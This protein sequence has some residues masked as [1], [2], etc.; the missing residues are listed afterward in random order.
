MTRVSYQMG[1]YV[2][3]EFHNNALLLCYVAFPHLH[4][5]VSLCFIGHVWRGKKSS[6]CAALFASSKVKCEFAYVWLR[7]DRF[8]IVRWFHIGKV[9]RFVVCE[10][11][12]SFFCNL[13]GR[14]RQFRSFALCS[15][16]KWNSF[17]FLHTNV[18]FCHI[19]EVEFHRKWFFR[20]KWH[21]QKT[22]QIRRKN[23]KNKCT[24]NFGEFFHR[25]D[26][27]II[28]IIELISKQSV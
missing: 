3:C 13:R 6:E 2:V 1:E 8:Y 4:A 28:I 26:Q 5:I 20:I 21:Y 22:V 15:C 14:E 12:L 25:L 11:F 7:C 19:L 16:G 18:E 9:L 10:A 24:E 17:F 23:V 27:S